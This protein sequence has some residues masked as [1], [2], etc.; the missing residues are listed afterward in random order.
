[1]NE[2][3]LTIWSE[4]QSQH[5]PLSGT[6]LTIG[7]GEQADLC[8]SDLGLSRVHASI[9]RDSKRV[10]VLDEGSTNGTFVNGQ[11]VTASGMPLKDGDQIS[12]GDTT[13]ITLKLDRQ[14]SASTATTNHNKATSSSS[15]PSSGAE[16]TGLPVVPITIASVVVIAILASVAAGIWYLR[17]DK[18]GKGIEVVQQITPLPSLPPTATPATSGTAPAD[19]A[20]QTVI[21][22]TADSGI[23]DLVITNVK[24][25]EI[26]TMQSSAKLYRQMSEQEQVYF[27]NKKAQ[28]IALMVGNR[29]QVFPDEAI[30]IIKYW[31]DAYVR[32]IGTGNTKL[33]A[34]DL[35]FMFKR[36]RTQFTPTIIRAFKANG[37]PP[38]V[39]V[40]LP[41]IE[42]EYR[43]ITTEN[44]AGAAGLFQFIGPTARGYGVD[45]SERTNIEK[46]APAAARYINDR[47][48]EFGADAVG[49]GL[50]IA[51]Y[52]RSPDSVRRDLHD[53]I[54]SQNKDRDFWILV[55]NKAKLD[56]WFQR[57][58]INYVPRF[59]AAAIIGE[60]PSAFGLKMR[61]LSTY[62][63]PDTSSDE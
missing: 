27:I 29:P 52:N 55:K 59:F 61:Q 1:M 57:E 14:K 16:A 2:A 60:N 13:K 39:G 44:F 50:S 49:V 63:E 47:L 62:T 10:W 24:A 40:Y 23:S 32:R 19:A 12:L 17:K 38:V 35:R 46:M 31:L 42:T 28:Q 4:G 58:N 15:L 22:E 26:G 18:S 9:N 3:T 45:P 11:R 8:L 54:N 20:D 34:E 37:A 41:V 56:A 25:S 43:N 48:A 33:W 30:S 7:R 21:E 36:A 53:V 5:L 51:G 6:R